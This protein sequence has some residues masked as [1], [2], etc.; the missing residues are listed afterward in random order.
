MMAL[1]FA[2]ILTRTPVVSSQYQFT[3]TTNEN[4]VECNK[5]E[6]KSKRRGIEFDLCRRR[7]PREEIARFSCAFARTHGTRSN[8]HINHQECVPRRGL[9][10]MLTV[11]D[12]LME[13]RRAF[14]RRVHKA[15]RRTFERCG[16][17][18]EQAQRTEHTAR[19]HEVD[20]VSVWNNK[21]VFHKYPWGTHFGPMPHP[22][23]AYS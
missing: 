16:E 14:I 18:V 20:R 7:G 2:T 23:S 22:P 5:D 21:S 17:L 10:Y 15:A 3:A 4:G 12:S 19:S 8:L 11:G 9:L 13:E 1:S 6:K